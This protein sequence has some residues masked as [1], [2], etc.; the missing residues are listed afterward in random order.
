M[1][2]LL[3]RTYFLK[4]CNRSKYFKIVKLEQREINEELKTHLWHLEYESSNFQYTIYCYNL[5]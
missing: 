5:E 1:D 3:N 2:H 4:Y